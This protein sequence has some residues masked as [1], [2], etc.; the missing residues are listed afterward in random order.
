MGIVATPG[1]MG[2]SYKPIKTY[3]E[4]LEVKL[5]KIISKHVEGDVEELTYA[6]LQLMEDECRSKK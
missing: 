2:E 4:W 1:M 5:R 6:I 3:N